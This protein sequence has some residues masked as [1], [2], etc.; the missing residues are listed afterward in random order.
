MT[1]KPPASAEQPLLL[2]VNPDK[3]LRTAGEARARYGAVVEEIVCKALG[4]TR[5]ANNGN[6]DV[7][8][9]A[10][11]HLDKCYIEI[12]SVRKS[13]KI[14]IYKWRIAKEN[15]AG[16]PLCYAIAVHNCKGA[17]SVRGIWKGMS[18]T[19]QNIL[20][21]P[22]ETVHALAEKQKL[23]QLVKPDPSSRMGY[24]RKGY[25][26]GYYNVPVSGF[27]GLKCTEQYSF[28][29]YGLTFKIGILESPL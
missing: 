18:E 15:Q 5:I 25:C 2:E 9:D 21:V 19:L 22:A 16:V 29:L 1:I 10:Y 24:K 7:V 6:Y 11:S 27:D 26:E 3:P 20:I 23:R 8:F 17:T 4:L 14:P 12:K 28:P 13:S